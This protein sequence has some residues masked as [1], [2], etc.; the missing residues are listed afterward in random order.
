MSLHI[1]YS[2]QES[3]HLKAW[4]ILRTEHEMYGSFEC[5]HTKYRILQA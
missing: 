2:H 4:K 5:G 1:Q 3:F